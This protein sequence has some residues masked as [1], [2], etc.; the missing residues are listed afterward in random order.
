[1]PKDT[2]I[3]D[4]KFLKKQV[5]KTNGGLMKKRNAFTLAEVL[6]TLGI[7]GIVA[8]MTM[9]ILI[10]KH[11][12]KVSAA[13]LKQAYSML[14]QA[15]LLAQKDYGEPK[16]WDSGTGQLN[17]GT[18]NKQMATTNFVEKYVI[19]YLK[20]VRSHGW[21]SLADVGYK[22]AYVALN[23]KTIPNGNFTNLSNTGYI[24][25]LNNSTFIIFSYNDYYIDGTSGPTELKQAVVYFDI[26]GRQKPNMFGRDFFVFQYNTSKGILEPYGQGLSRTNLLKSYCT[27]ST[28]WGNIACSALIMLDGWEIK[29]DYP[30]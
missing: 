6:I 2:V 11:Q 1:M 3:C 28:E 19:P 22:K 18:N 26:N 20:G 5:M 8:A 30:W 4:A 14:S 25:E 29:D 16:Y 13:R 15:I 27:K 21:T 24:L 9:P 7:I 12:K 10:E 23:G 17:T